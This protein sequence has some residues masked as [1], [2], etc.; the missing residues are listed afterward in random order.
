M[1]YLKRKGQKGFYVPRVLEPVEDAIF[2]TQKASEPGNERR[3]ELPG[4]IAGH[5]VSDI[6]ARFYLAAAN[7]ADVDSISMQVS[8]VAGRN[9]PGEIRLDFLLHSN[10]IRFPV[11][12]DGEYW[13]RTAEAKAKDDYQEDLVNQI[14]AGT[15]SMR[16][17]RV[18]GTDLETLEEAR[19]AVGLVL[20]NHYSNL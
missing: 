14:L 12:T 16:V 15:Y 6:E 9:L 17:Q 11:F 8:L 10:G 19:R 13:H 7:H 18:P 2:K 3:E 4:L 20:V 1:T 5:K